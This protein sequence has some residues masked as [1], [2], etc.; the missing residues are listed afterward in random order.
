[1]RLAL[2]EARQYGLDRRARI[3]N[4]SLDYFKKPN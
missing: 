1:M 4:A 3:R 2:N